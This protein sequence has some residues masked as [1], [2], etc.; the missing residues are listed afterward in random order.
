MKRSNGTSSPT[1]SVT[2]QMK[3]VRFSC[4]SLETSSNLLMS[5]EEG[6]KAKILFSVFSFFNCLDPDSGSEF[7]SGSTK[8]LN[9]DPFSI[10]NLPEILQQS[11]LLLDSV[12]HI[13][14]FFRFHSDFG[15]LL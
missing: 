8:M 3:G 5:L 10:F 11:Y 13:F 6:K 2:R 15:L 1:L 4:P 12:P 9:T 7:V 14:S